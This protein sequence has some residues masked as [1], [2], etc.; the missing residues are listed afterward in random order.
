MGQNVWAGLVLLI[1][2]LGGSTGGEAGFTTADCW[3]FGTQGESTGI[4]GIEG[5][6]GSYLGTQGESTG[7]TGTS[8]RIPRIAW[9]ISSSVS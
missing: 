8:G 9:R 7:A 5:A 1:T 2:E 3:I 6:A 4:T